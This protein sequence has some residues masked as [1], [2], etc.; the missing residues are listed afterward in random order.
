MTLWA[1]SRSLAL[2]HIP[3]ATAGWPGA[4]VL[5]LPRPA[6]S[7]EPSALTEDDIDEMVAFGRVACVAGDGN[8]L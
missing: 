1:M 2:P 4:A 5:V 6:A 3:R 8:R 7:V